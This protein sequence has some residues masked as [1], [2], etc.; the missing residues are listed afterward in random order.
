MIIERVRAGMRRARL[1][2]RRLGRTPLDVD[3]EAIRRD[4]TRGLSLA[5]L[6]KLHGVSRT[7]VRRIIA[8]AVPQ[9]CVHE[10]PQTAEN[11]RPQ[12]AA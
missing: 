9:R 2:G 5:Q 6:A 8:Q 12:Q 1:E 7:S 3:R 10:V 11:T 4:R